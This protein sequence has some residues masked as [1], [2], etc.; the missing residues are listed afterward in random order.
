M[1]MK[2][3]LPQWLV[4]TGSGQELIAMGYQD[5]VTIASEFDVSKI[6]PILNQDGAFTPYP[7]K[8]E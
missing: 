8:D 5:D 6:V 1:Q 2:D 3:K 4:K 7:N